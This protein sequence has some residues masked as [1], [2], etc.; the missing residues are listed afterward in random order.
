MAKKVDPAPPPTFEEALEKLDKCI[1]Q[2]EDG[3][4]GLEQSLACY[5]EG[6]GLLKQCYGML[7]KA[8][9]R[10]QELTGATEEGQPQ[11]RPFKST[12]AE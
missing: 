6:V 10:V 2:L 3:Q 9:K 11:T 4:V 8:E 1:E 12:E 7:E 5:E